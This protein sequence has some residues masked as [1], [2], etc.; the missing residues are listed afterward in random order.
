MLETFENM[1][2]KCPLNE[3]LHIGREIAQTQTKNSLCH[4][5]IIETS[6]LIPIQAETHYTITKLFHQLHRNTF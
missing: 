3:K 6:L 1:Q 4:S 5:Y 2:A